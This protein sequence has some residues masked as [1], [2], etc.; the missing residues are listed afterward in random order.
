MQL[1]PVIRCL[2]ICENAV[3]DPDNPHR[4]SLLGLASTIR[5]KDEPPYPLLLREVCV[6]VQMTECV[7][8]GDLHVQI[9]HPDSGDLLFRT[10]SRRLDFGDNP[11]EIHGIIFRIRDLAI[12]R[13][14]LYT[15]EFCYN[16]ITEA[17]GYLLMR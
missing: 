8:A 6:F 3:R 15:F 7:G 16:G 9:F 2:M 10:K 14:G 5:S 17:E 4:V 13:Q 12:P 1:P 11:L